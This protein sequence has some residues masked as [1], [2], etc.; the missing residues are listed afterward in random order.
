MLTKQTE[1]K[2]RSFV[3]QTVRAST[4]YNQ[5]IYNITNLLICSTKRTYVV[6]MVGTVHNVGDF[7]IICRKYM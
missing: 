6:L 1:A 7:I 5:N 4:A 2:R 3:S